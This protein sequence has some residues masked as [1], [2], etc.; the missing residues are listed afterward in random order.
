MPDLTNENPWGAPAAPNEMK[1]CPF[2]GE[3]IMA[4]ARKCRYCQE[5]LDPQ[6]RDLGPASNAVERLMLPVGRP[7]SAIA[8][9]YLGLFSVLP[10]FGIAAIIVS[11]VAL[12]TLSR[13][14]GLH[15]RGRAWFGLIMGVGMT[16]LYAIPIALAL[17][18]SVTKQPSL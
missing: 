5:Y 2:C 3:I 15:G 16:L 8:A 4:V 7:I 18:I 12:R 11:L 13:N 1:N 9:G 6:L 17:I 10:L 14:P